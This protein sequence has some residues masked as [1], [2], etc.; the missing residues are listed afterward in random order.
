MKYGL[1]S[2]VLMLSFAAMADSEVMIESDDSGILSYC[3]YDL[4]NLALLQFDSVNEALYI[5]I[6]NGNEIRFESRNTINDD[7][8]TAQLK[9]T[10]VKKLTSD[11]VDV[12]R[13]GCGAQ[14]SRVDRAIADLTHALA[15][16]SGESVVDSLRS[17]VV[18]AFMMWLA[19]ILH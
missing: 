1:L 15:N 19:C 2:I 5:S 3:A 13:S 12:L 14:R 4:K 16:D 9:S 18:E 10:A 17:A 7:Q 6:E 8:L 11:T